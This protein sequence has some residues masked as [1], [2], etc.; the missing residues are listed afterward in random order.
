MKI[1][2]IDHKFFL[3]NQVS[4][5]QQNSTTYTAIDFL[6]MRNQVRGPFPEQDRRNVLYGLMMAG[7]PSVNS[8]S[9]EYMNL[10]RPI[11][12]GALAEVS[13]NRFILHLTQALFFRL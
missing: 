4:N 5:R 8:L 1:K 9:S 7:V 2:S 11:M 12:Y 10:E 13:C 6:L 3:L